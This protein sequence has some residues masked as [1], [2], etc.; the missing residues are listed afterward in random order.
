MSFAVAHAA[1][2]PGKRRLDRDAYLTVQRIYYP[3]FTVG[4]ISE[5]ASIVAAIA[6][7]YFT[8][9]ENAA[10]RWTL[11]ALVALVVVQAVY[12]LVTHPV[13]RVW[14]QDQQLSGAGARLLATGRTLE[15]DDGDDWVKLRDR[16]EH[17]HVLR[18]FF[19]VAAFLCLA[20]GIMA[21]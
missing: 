14:T 6:M 21:D 5:P 3:G 8:P 2:F 18:A 12:W 16:W 4:S 1:E 7:L 11:A 9:L 10:F 20:I 17:S 15:T 13:N 19:A